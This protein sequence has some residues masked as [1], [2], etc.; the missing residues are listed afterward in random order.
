V[1]KTTCRS[2]IATAD[3]LR[4]L[5]ARA[6]TGAGAERADEGTIADRRG[7]G[8]HLA[9]EGGAATSGDPST[10]VGDAAGHDLAA[11]SER[12]GGDGHVEDV[13]SSLVDHR[14]LDLDLL[15]VAPVDVV[16]DAKVVLCVKRVGGEGD[17]GERCA[18]R[19]QPSPR[20]PHSV[21]TSLAARLRSVNAPT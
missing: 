5:G 4:S 10:H 14:P 8:R 19:C 13:L 18:H 16:E 3:A 20:T 21:R 1:T 11:G 2:K 7:N 9:N 17:D 12:L 6:G 15:R